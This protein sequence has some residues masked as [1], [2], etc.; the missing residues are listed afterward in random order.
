M[1]YLDEK[2][3][4]TALKNYG[5]NFLF[6]EETDSTNEHLK[7][8]LSTSGF[9]DPIALVAERQMKGKGTKGRQWADDPEN[10]LKFSMLVEYKG[11]EKYLPRL[12]PLLAL[13]LAE[14]FQ[15]LDP[16]VR[17]K[18]PNDLIKDF[19]KL[20]GILIEAVRKDEKLFLIFGIGINLFNS[21]ELNREVNRKISYLFEEKKQEVLRRSEVVEKLVISVL[22]TISPCVEK[23]DIVFCERWKK[24]DFFYDKIISLQSPTEQLTGIEKGI[25][26]SGELKL[27]TD[28]KI[29]EISNGELSIV[30]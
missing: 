16:S 6:L 15:N 20:S 7:R 12:S 29:K 30:L 1:T 17:I 11:M 28:G 23:D 13:N 5:V 25:T 18:W 24:L 19:G 9:S 21:S 14:I 8:V 3:T 26:P 27:L 4:R 2:N 10:C 22:K